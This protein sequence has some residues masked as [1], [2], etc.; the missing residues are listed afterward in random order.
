MDIKILVA[1]HKKAQMPQDC[2]YFPLHVGREGKQ[3][4]GYIGDNTGDNISSKNKSFCELTGVYWAWK[5]VKCDYIGLVHYRRLFAKG[6]HLTSNGKWKA[7]L[8]QKDFEALLKKTNVVLPRKRH[9]Y[10]ETSRS[11]YEHAHNPNDLKIL[12]EVI[13]ERHPEFLKSLNDVLNKTA[14]HRFNMFVMRK[15]IFDSY[16]EWL[17]DILFELEKRIDI[18]NYNPYN[19][20]VFGFIGERLLDVW[21]TAKNL[22]YVEQ[23]VLFMERQNWI[24]KAFQFL[25]RK[26]TG[27]IDYEH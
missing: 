19:A 5:N 22:N 26:F 12:E 25:K 4:L 21:I 8:S 10:I 15:D 3:N 23:N 1:T 17:F 7:V 24:S 27:G 9:Y 13:T 6:F 2:C 20:R 18:S 16:C 11:Q 14:G